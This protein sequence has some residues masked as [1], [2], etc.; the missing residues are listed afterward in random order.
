[1]ISPEKT[2]ELVRQTNSLYLNFEYSIIFLKIWTGQS[3]LTVSLSLIHRQDLKKKF[4]STKQIIFRVGGLNI[5]IILEIKFFFFTF[6]ENYSRRFVNQLIKKNS[7]LILPLFRIASKVKAFWQEFEHICNRV[8]FHDEN[9][10]QDKVL[11]IRI[12]S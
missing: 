6:T 2:V 9:Y 10:Q 8:D 11:V 3:L 7:G 4:F 12:K 5:K 1:M